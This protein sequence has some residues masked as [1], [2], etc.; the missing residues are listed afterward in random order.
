METLTD[1]PQP[2]DR[3]AKRRSRVSRLR[4]YV[5]VRCVGADVERRLMFAAAWELWP[6]RQL[7]DALAEALT[8][9]A[10]ARAR[11]GGASGPLAL[12]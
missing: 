8:S 7:A 9:R 5:W 4:S 11:A 6:E 1:D 12:G 2:G 10:E 3:S